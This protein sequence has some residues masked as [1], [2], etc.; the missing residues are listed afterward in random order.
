MSP[1]P[2]ANAATASSRAAPTPWRPCSGSTE[3]V[4]SGV[5]GD[6]ERLGAAQVLDRRRVVLGDLRHPDLVEERPRQHLD[7]LQA[8]QLTDVEP[9]RTDAGR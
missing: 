1:R 7:L 6:E 3:S 5:D 9:S 4:V 2:L 8:C